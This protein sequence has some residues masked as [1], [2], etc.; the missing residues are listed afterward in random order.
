MLSIVGAVACFA[1]VDAIIKFLTLEYSVPL[2]VWLR[3][4]VQA[5]LMAIWLSW[6]ARWSLIRTPRLKLHLVRSIVLMV[7]TLCFFSALRWLPLADATAILYFT[8]VVVVLIAVMVL[9]ERVTPMHWMFVIAGF[10]GVVLIV[11]PG[12]SIVHGAAVL[13]I[14]AACTHALFQVMTRKLSAEDPRVLLFYPAMCGT[15]VMTPVLPFLD[16]SLSH[17][18]L[19]LMVLVGMIGTGGHALLV[20]AFKRAP[21]SAVA[22]F[23]YTHLVWAAL[24]GWIA[25]G[26]FPD[27]LS[28]LGMTVIALSGLLLW[29]YETRA[30]SF[31]ASAIQRAPFD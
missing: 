27:V 30:A 23:T 22:P 21:A 31:A 29:W 8:P 25:F 13:A 12:A 18:H 1:L 24:L 15:V 20:Y 26:Q 2:L 17:A 6:S 16:L 7:S 28:L 14:V 4:F 10:I 3:W 11:R 19:A 9:K 5:V